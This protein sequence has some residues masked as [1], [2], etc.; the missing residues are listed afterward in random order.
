MI[1]IMAPLVLVAGLLLSGLFYLSQHV[2][3]PVGSSVIGERP[4]K[5]MGNQLV[6]V[7]PETL[8]V[9]QARLMNM[10]YA[11]GKKIGLKDPEVLQSL[12]LQETMGGTMKSYRVANPG[13]EAYFG[14]LQIKLP[15]ARDVLKYNP[16]L[17][18]E[19]DFH[20]RTDDEVKANL[21]L[22]DEFNL[23]V[24]GRYLKHLQDQYGFRGRELVNAYNRGPGGVRAVD[25]NY[26]YAIG[27]EQKLSVWKSKRK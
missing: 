14:V 25:N 11:I 24:G 27:A 16:Q 7:V 4:G 2:P 19:H 8:T 1:R 22:N 10:A 5:T 20:T 12:L 23:E 18:S 15:A 9:R 6:S 3:T 17:Y 21:I 13:P 26:H